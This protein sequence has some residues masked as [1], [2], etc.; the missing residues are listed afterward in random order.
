MIIENVDMSFLKDIRVVIEE[1][2]ISLSAEKLDR[3]E[4]LS[5]RDS[6]DRLH[7]IIFRKELKIRKNG[8]LNE[9]KIDR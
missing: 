1:T 9:Q 5:I 2:I 6:L 3:Y 8:G 7:L 4:H